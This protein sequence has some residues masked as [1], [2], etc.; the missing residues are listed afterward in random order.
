MVNGAR[1]RLH[2]RFRCGHQFVRGRRHHRQRSVLGTGKA[3]RYRAVNHPDTRV[4]Q[5]LANLA[6]FRRPDRGGQD[7][8]PA[9]RHMCDKA[10]ITKDYLLCLIPVHHHDKHDVCM[11]ANRTGIGAGH[12]AH[13]GKLRH[14]RITQ[15]KSACFETIGDQVLCKPRS[16]ISKP[17]NTG[18]HR[19]LLAAPLQS[20]PRCGQ[21]FSYVLSRD[22]LRQS[23][24]SGGS[25]RH[26]LPVCSMGLF[27]HVACMIIGRTCISPEFDDPRQGQFQAE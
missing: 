25:N 22:F 13:L 1:Y 6:R 24:A 19:F 7:N 12:P 4:G 17:Y 15:I 26:P 16:H 21:T 14:A 27:H 11:T 23:A 5:C 20:S 2:D 9:V 3:A 10:A 8:D 18:F